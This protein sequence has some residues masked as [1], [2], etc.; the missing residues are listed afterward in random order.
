ML[1]VSTNT[2]S[3]LSSSYKTK[4]FDATLDSLNSLFWNSAGRDCKSDTPFFPLFPTHF[5]WP[6]NF[7]TSKTS[8]THLASSQPHLL[9]QN[10]VFWASYGVLTHAK[11][12]CS[13]IASPEHGVYT[14]ITM[15]DVSN[16]PQDVSKVFP[17][18]LKHIVVPQAKA[19][20]Y[21]SA[22]LIT[23]VTQ[24]QWGAPESD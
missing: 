13:N 16:T 20:M 8:G 14:D 3:S 6:V 10:H 1:C 5:F 21:I 18:P 23:P 7:L 11:L 15:L 2:I 22:P 19:Q 9:F 4:K 12:A 24:L 17:S